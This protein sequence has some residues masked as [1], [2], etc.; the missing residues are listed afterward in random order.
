MEAIRPQQ[1]V[2]AKPF[3]RGRVRPAGSAQV[4]P[5]REKIAVLDGACSH[6]AISESVVLVLF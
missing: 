2:G 1:A 3:F 6:G 5:K 4:W